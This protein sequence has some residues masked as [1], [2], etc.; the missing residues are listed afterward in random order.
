MSHCLCGI[1]V[2]P[3]PTARRRSLMASPEKGS[4]DNTCLTR[5]GIM[6]LVRKKVR[7]D[8]KSC[9]FYFESNCL[10]RT[11]LH[12]GLNRLGQ[13]CSFRV[14]SLHSPAHLHTQA[15]KNPPKACGQIFANVSFITISFRCKNLSTSTA[16]T[17]CRE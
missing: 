3:A 13:I 11:Q 17:A 1:Y 4:P 9:V 15:Q 16:S 6:S 14:L 12:V 5:I 2:S 7:T 8:I 10:R